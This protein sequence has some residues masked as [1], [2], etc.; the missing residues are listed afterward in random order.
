MNK[1]LNK[2]LKE[3]IRIIPNFP[4]KGILFQDVTSITDDS[5][6]FKKVIVELS[7]YA[8]K[9]KISKVA[10]IEARGF[11]FGSAVAIQCS[12][13]FI[14]IRKKGKLP[15]KIYKQKYKLEYGIDEIEVHKNAATQNDKILIIDDLIASGGTAAAAARLMGKFNPKEIQFHFIINL[16]NLG[17]MKKIQKNFKSKS[18]LNCLG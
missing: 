5:K 12:L 15:G 14:P 17:G 2:E 9:N 13:P 10:G 3:K 18:F 6:L 7:N 8:R 11:I 1:K 4:K 16:Y